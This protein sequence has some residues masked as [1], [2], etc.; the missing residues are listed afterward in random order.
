MIRDFPKD[1]CVINTP[2]TARA[3]CPRMPHPCHKIALLCSFGTTQYLI[4]YYRGL[5]T[6]FSG[7]NHRRFHTKYRLYLVDFVVHA[8]CVCIKL[9]ETCPGKMGE[10]AQKCPRP[11]VARRP[12][13]SEPGTLPHTNPPKQSR[14]P[15]FITPQ[16]V[17]N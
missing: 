16:T 3:I 15:L 6:Y 1:Q 5:C 7:Q 12:R 11:L 4:S 13:F 2:S 10:N 9:P 17:I 8:V 14:K